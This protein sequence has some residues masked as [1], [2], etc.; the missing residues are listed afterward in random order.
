MENRINSALASWVLCDDFDLRQKLFE[1]NEKWPNADEII[2]ARTLLVKILDDENKISIQT[3]HAFCQTLIK[4]FPF[5]AKIKPNFELLDEAREKLLLKQAQKEVLRQENLWDSIRKISG[6]INEESLQGLV[7]ELLSKKEKI[8]DIAEMVENIFD[9]FLLSKNQNEEEIFQKF[10]QQI[11]HQ[12]AS[13]LEETGLASNIEIASKIKKFLENPLIENFSLYKSAFFTN[14]GKPRKIYSK[15]KHLLPLID[16]QCRIITECEDK[17]NSLKIANDSALL[18]H[19]ADAILKNYSH[20]KREKALLDYDDLI[21]ETNKLLANP[22][23]SDWIKMKMDG[24]FDHILI[25]EAQDTNH[26]QWNII[27]ALSED[28]FSGFGASNKERSIFIVGDEKQS[29]YSFQG[30]DPDISAEIFSYFSSK[31]EGKL[32]KIELHKSFRSN[33]TILDA[34]DKVFADPQRRN[35]IS[36]I[37]TNIKHIAIRSGVGIVEIWP[38]ITNEKIREK[39]SYEWKIDFACNEEKQEKEILAEIIAKKIKGW[40]ENKRVISAKERSVNYGDIMILLRRRSDGFSQELAKSFHQYQIPF[41]SIAK[42]KFSES[43]L[44]CD[45]LSAAKFALLPQDDLNLACLLKSPFFN[46]TEEELLELCVKKNEQ[47]CSLF[48]VKKNLLLEE[49]IEKSQQLNCLEFFYFLLHEKNHQKNFIAYFGHES[50]EI[51]DKFLLI[52]ADFCHNTSPNLQQFLEFVEKTDPEISLTAAEENRVRISTI[53][54]AKGL[55]S[56]IVIL[57][58]CCFDFNRLPAGKEKIHWIDNLPL[59]CARKEN[60]NEIIKNHRLKKFQQAKDEY[61]RLLYVAMT[62]AEDELYIAGYGG[63][64]DKESWYEIIKEALLANQS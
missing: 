28:F 24:A 43:L 33:A 21:F 1:L 2:K 56:P 11:N 6:K 46:I 36:K 63:G 17:L 37:A 39:Q 27:K 9:L 42:I 34:V 54:S 64:S 13:Q 49:I 61:L 47:K 44:I 16:E 35:S 14:E 12:L 30:S 40:I 15:T 52:I 4:I 19:F 55:Q 31:L 5:E 53:H 60:E 38:Q 41:E 59:W 22:D 7:L 48:E 29:I 20:L 50:L 51:L 23:F 57:P 10:L 26:E 45:L 32:K 18:L 62:R 3:I 58:D 8:A 25:D